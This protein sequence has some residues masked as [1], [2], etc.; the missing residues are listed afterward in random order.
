LCAHRC[1][2]V[3][4]FGGAAAR[5]SKLRLA[6]ADLVHTLERMLS[7]DGVIVWCVCG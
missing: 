7:A 4:V 6:A 1:V 2:R 3:C 5:V